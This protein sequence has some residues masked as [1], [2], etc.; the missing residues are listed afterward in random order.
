M[1][2]FSHV[3]GGGLAANLARVLPQGLEGR[4]DRSTWQIPAIFSLIG[5]LGNV[6]LADLERTLNL[7]VG[8]IAIVDPSVA[9]AATKRLNDRGI[10][11]WIM[12]DVVAA[13]D[14]EPNSADYIQGAKGV[15]GGAVRLLGSYAS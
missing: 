15:D 3:T 4:V 1:R 8:M 13:G 12:G 10:P 14:P 5:S 9:E 2:G 7:G 6:P 11:S